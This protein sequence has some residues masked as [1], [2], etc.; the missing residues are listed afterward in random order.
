[1]VRVHIRFILFLRIYFSKPSWMKKK[2]KAEPIDGIT[3][4]PLEENILEW[5]Y[6]INGTAGTPYEG[7]FLGALN[8]ESQRRDCSELHKRLATE[9]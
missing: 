7:H 4:M 1:M 5:H 9:E 8:L 3:A 6:V 2:L